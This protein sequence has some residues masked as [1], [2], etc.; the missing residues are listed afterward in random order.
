MC[1]HCCFTHAQ[2][3]PIK[4][5]YENETPENVDLE[6][7]AEVAQPAST[8]NIVDT[9]S[10][11]ADVPGSGS[12]NGSGSGSS[13]V[14]SSSWSAR[15]VVQRAEG[16]DRVRVTPAWSLS[17]ALGASLSPSS[18]ALSETS[19]AAAIVRQVAS[20]Q[21]FGLVLCGC[22]G[23]GTPAASPGHRQRGDGDGD[24]AGAGP[25]TGTGN[26]GG[27]N[28]VPLSG[29][30]SVHGKWPSLGVPSIIGSRHGPSSLSLMTR[31]WHGKSRHH[32]RGGHR[33]REA[34]AASTSRFGSGRS[35]DGSH[36]RQGGLVSAVNMVI[37]NALWELVG[38]VAAGLLRSEPAPAVL[39]V[40][41]SKP[42]LSATI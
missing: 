17:E 34:A 24:G 2:N 21:V 27:G 15:E 6:A 37:N 13:G 32:A 39:A 25:G 42:A 35:A 23:S 14:H 36:P 3:G 11:T 7:G 4:T 28:D 26:G 30:R 20:T 33:A 12:G 1:V 8:S 9:P 22:A 18:S 38:D 40:R 19:A 29:T 31:S 16:L 10:A 41:A 5:L